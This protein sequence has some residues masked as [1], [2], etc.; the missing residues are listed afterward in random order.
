MHRAVANSLVLLCAF[1]LT[2]T[3][4]AQNPEPVNKE[5]RAIFQQLIEINTTD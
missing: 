1:A 4:R 3:A 5:A 2:A